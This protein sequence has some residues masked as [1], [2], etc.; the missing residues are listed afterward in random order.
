MPDNDIEWGQGAV[1][2]DI[3]WG[4]AQLNNTIGFGAIYENSPSGDTNLIGGTPTPPAPAGIANNYSMNF[5]GVNDSVNIFSGST[6]STFQNIGNA[7]SNYTISFWFKTT[8]STVFTS[9]NSA[10]YSSDHII[11]LRG[12]YNSG[13]YNVPFNISAASNISIGRGIGNYTSGGFVGRIASTTQ[14]LN[15]NNWHHV[16]ITVTNNGT[17]IIYIDNS[18]STNTGLPTDWSTHLVGVDT[19]VGSGTADLQI[20][21]RS[22]NA[23]SKVNFF[24]GSIDEFAI[25]NTDLSST[26]IQSIYNAKGNNLTKDLSTIE[27]S[28]LKYWNR[29]GD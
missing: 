19:S 1:N 9:S 6:P 4:K 28:N 13:N 18:V 22:T 11:E 27:P 14:G 21:A 2:N 7:T 25:W 5:D 29:M 15:D 8:D 10:W 3:G 20:G 26:Q 23:G 24:N 16:A 12:R 17:P